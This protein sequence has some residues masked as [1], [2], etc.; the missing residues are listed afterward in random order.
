MIIFIFRKRDCSLDVL[1][2]MSEAG[3]VERVELGDVSLGNSFL[4]LG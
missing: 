1:S 3:L 4:A 2:I